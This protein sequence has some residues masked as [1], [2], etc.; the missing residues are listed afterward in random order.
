M[1]GAAGMCRADN[2]RLPTGARCGGTQWYAAVIV[3]ACQL[4]F[5]ARA[6]IQVTYTGCTDTINPSGGNPAGVMWYAG[7]ESMHRSA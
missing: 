7:V 4:T 6:C 5:G 3:P 2:C 1:G